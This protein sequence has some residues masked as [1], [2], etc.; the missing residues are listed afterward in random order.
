[1]TQ[2][3]NKIFRITDILEPG[4]VLIVVTRA[5]FALAILTIISA[6]LYLYNREETWGYFFE[7]PSSGLEFP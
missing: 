6:V 5:A 7:M 3:K 1:M 2:R 4:D